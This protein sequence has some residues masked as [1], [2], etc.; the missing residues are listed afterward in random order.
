MGIYTE[1]FNHLLEA[2]GVHWSDIDIPPTT[3]ANC[4]AKDRYTLKQV[5]K[6]ALALDMPVY[7][8][9]D[10]TGEAAALVRLRNIVLELG[11]YL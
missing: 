8:V 9:L 4:K 3:L 6:I 5:E 2:R 10:V 1:R 7:L 11:K